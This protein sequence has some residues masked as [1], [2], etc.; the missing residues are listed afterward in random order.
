MHDTGQDCLSW[1]G[2]NAAVGRRCLKDMLYRLFTY[3]S[4][5]ESRSDQRDFAR[6]ILVLTSRDGK[7]FWLAP[8]GPFFQAIDV[9]GIEDAE[10]THLKAD[11][12]DFEWRASEVLEA[13]DSVMALDLF[14]QRPELSHY[15]PI[16]RVGP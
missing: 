6:S 3:G 10:P 2:D 12:D 4:P 8:A 13:P 1:D 11:A 16:R 5:V 14:G 15:W 7:I 9:A